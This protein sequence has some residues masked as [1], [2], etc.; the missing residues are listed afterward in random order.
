MKPADECTSGRPIRKINVVTQEVY[1]P[2]AQCIKSLLPM[3]NKP[4]TPSLEEREDVIQEHVEFRDVS[5]IPI[6]SPSHC[7]IYTVCV[8]RLA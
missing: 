7:G 8:C 1:F 2:D 5:D 4:I 3:N 6:T